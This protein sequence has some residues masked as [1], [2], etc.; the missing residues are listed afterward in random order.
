MATFFCIFDS[1]KSPY[2]STISMALQSRVRTLACSPAVIEQNQTSSR[3]STA[4]KVD[5]TTSIVDRIK[6]SLS[7]IIAPNGAM[8]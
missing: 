7:D 3:Q 4:E 8:A 2:F 6:R 1:W 5:A